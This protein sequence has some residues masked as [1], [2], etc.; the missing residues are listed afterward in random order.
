[1]QADAM[2]AWT[3]SEQTPPSGAHRGQD[4]RRRF[5]N[6]IGMGGE[7]PGSRD[8]ESAERPGTNTN[9]DSEK[10]WTWGTVP[11]SGRP[12]SF[13]TDSSLA[14]HALGHRPAFS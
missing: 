7:S 14:S 6:S 12:G 9:A 13:D 8:T 5:P 11:A 1:M 2:P 3:A 10:T 4:Y